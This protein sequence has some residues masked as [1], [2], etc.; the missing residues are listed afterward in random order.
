[1]K[2]LFK[3]FIKNGVD[4]AIDYYEIQIDE[5]AIISYFHGNPIVF[6]VTLQLSADS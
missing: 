6:V 4:A 3:C 5:G 1:M 2:S